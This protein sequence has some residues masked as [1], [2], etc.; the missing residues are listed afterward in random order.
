MSK[1]IRTSIER[2]LKSPAYF[3]LFS[4][5]PVLWMY[6]YN[7][8]GIL[9]ADLFR[10]L[11]VSFVL[12]LVLFWILE[13]EIRHPQTSALIVFLL[14]LAFFNYGFV[15]TLLNSFRIIVRDDIPAIVW[16][17]IFILVSL[18]IGRYGR[19]WPN[20]TISITL[21]LMTIILLLFPS[22][23]LMVYAVKR[24]APLERKSDNTV[25]VSVNST[26]PDIYY[27]VLDS[28]TR[29]DVM[30]NKFGY[31]NSSFINSLQNMGFYVADCSQT[32]YAST[33][34]SL[35]STLNMDYLQ[36]IS[37]AF[38]SDE[39][40][41]LYAFGAL[42]SN[43]LRSTLTNAGYKT[44]AFA[45]GFTWIEWRDADK[46][47]APAKYGELTEF[48]VAVLSST[49][50]RVLDDF[51]IVNLDDIHAEHYRQRTRLAL[52]SFDEILTIPSPKFVFIHIIA[53]HPPY[54]LDE[55]GDNVMP[56]QI[57]DLTGYKNQA[58][59]ISTAILPQ[60]QK[61]I[62]ESANP[63]VIILQ[64]DHGELGSNHNDIVKILN[65]Y[66]LPG[67]IDKLYPS[68]SPVNSFRIVLDSYFGLD[69]P[70][71]EDVSYY[72]TLSDRYDFAVIP[73]TCPA[74]VSAGAIGREKINPSR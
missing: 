25:Q 53:P 74:T 32:N 43:S 71:L 66:Y 31:D 20:K 47:I 55:N 64:G 5:Y 59:F 23:R 67:H 19:Y 15:R 41:L 48:E 3:I 8:H 70:L 42:D 26:S 60:L 49:Y 46:F 56:D 27:I 45:S 17:I 24:A 7:V 58:K 13:L 34:L 35:S 18:L 62:N 39:N 9:L 40:D 72:S 57:D 44:V 21:N 10:P 33:S 30:K 14:F 12:A 11:I 1:N 68:I 69:F 50:A 36:N 29:S 2:F 4:V 16:M 65:A 63:P 22:I 37:D 54:S 28:Y 6:A 73:N 61:L 51:G 38:Q 52:N